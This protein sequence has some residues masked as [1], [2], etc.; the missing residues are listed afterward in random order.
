MAFNPPE[1]ERK[2]VL[3]YCCRISCFIFLC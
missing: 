1:S 2:T 3:L